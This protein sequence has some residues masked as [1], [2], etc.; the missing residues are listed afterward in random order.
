M[1]DVH[2]H[3]TY[4]HMYSVQEGD[5]THL[6]DENMKL[7]YM[8]LTQHKTVLYMFV[9][10]RLSYGLWNLIYLC[11]ISFPQFQLTIFIAVC[12]IEGIL[13]FNTV[14]HILCF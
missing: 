8:K 9:Y 10:Q 1:A 3:S 4:V 13:A 6:Y 11:A 2:M 5:N 7:R 14:A 12:Y